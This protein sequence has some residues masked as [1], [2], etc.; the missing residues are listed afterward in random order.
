MSPVRPVHTP[1]VVTENA[2]DEE[3]WEFIFRMPPGR[4]AR[5]SPSSDPFLSP[6]GR[7]QCE[8]MRG[9]H[10]RNNVHAGPCI[11]PHYFKRTGPLE[12]QVPS[13]NTG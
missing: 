1:I 3:F 4:R 8:A 9:V 11:G 10:E 6:G 13:K 5:A 2:A 7:A 12:P